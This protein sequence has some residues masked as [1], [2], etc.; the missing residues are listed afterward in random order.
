MKNDERGAVMYK[1]VYVEITNICNMNCSFCHGHKRAA[2]RMTREE[3]A[4]VLQKLQGVTEYIYYHLM[5]EPLTHPELADF[6]CMARASGYK[7]IITTNGTLLNK[8]GEYILGSGVHKVN[9]SI[10]SFEGDDTAAHERYLLEIADFAK[11]AAERGTIVV[12]RL[13][14]KGYD[15]GRNDAAL[16]ILKESIDGEWR[17]NTRGVRIRERVYLEYG[18]RFEWPDPCAEVKGAKFFCYGLSDQFGILSDGTVVPCCLDSDGNIPLGN[19]YR[20][21][22]EEILG[23][24]RARA[25]VEGFKCGK[26]TEELCQRCGYAQ[27]FV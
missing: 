21:S 4:L 7:S 25:M 3:F 12:L 5:G 23:S 11:R 27:R 15:G 10:H 22:T 8:K 17:E 9:I 19:I 1:K 16:R 20:D 24:A 18:E 26:A 14:N 13:W 2:R 6:L